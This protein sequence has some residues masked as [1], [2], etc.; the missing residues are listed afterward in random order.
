MAETVTENEFGQP[1][2]PEVP[3][4]TGASRPE[5]IVHTG[6][7]CQLEPL[8]VDHSAELWEAIQLDPDGA[9]WTYSPAVKPSGRDECDRFVAQIAASGDPLYFAVRD[10]GTGKPAGWATFM[11]IDPPA[12]V[13]E[14]GSIHYTEA[15]K[16]TVAATEAMYL[17]M[18][19]AFEDLGYRRYEWKCHSLNEPSKRAAERYGFVYEGTFRQAM[20]LK[21]RSRDT[22]WYSIIDSEWPAVKAGFEAWLDPANFDATGQ[23]IKSLS[24]LRS[25]L[26]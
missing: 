7:A 3:D 26:A 16:R 1:V 24:A 19:H 13:I 9:N 5:R 23:Q 18:R 25:S 4:W 20:V 15:L 21:G 8:S 2:G 6:R 11:R 12:G 22:T 14:V 10:L 17:M